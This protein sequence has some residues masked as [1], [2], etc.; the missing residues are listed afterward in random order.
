MEGVLK[1]AKVHKAPVTFIRKSVHEG[2]EDS[3]EQLAAL[4][5]SNKEVVAL[6]LQQLAPHCDLSTRDVLD[7]FG[8]IQREDLTPRF[9]AEFLDQLFGAE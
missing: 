7:T 6:L 5:Q 9:T 2:E 8:E 4:A 1:I 3:P